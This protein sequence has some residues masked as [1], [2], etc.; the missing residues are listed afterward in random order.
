MAEGEMS[1]VAETMGESK[2]VQAVRGGVEKAQ[3]ANKE[4]WDIR[5]T[6]QDR[7]KWHG[8]GVYHE[9]VSNMNKVIDALYNNKDSAFL[10][11]VAAQALK[12]GVKLEGTALAVGSATLDVMYNSITWLPRKFL[13]VPKDVFKRM[14]LGVSEA[15][16]AATGAVGSVVAGEMRAVQGVKEGVSAVLTAPEVAKTMM[17]NRVDKIVDRIKNPRKIEVP[18]MEGLKLKKLKK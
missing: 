14:A 15:R 13:P 8:G 7:L 10:T 5:K 17:K 9:H 6:I 18:A 2:V 12:V 1:A 3:Q 11:R 16:V 4:Y